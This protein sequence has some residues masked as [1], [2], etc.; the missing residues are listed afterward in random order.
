MN[1]RWDDLPITCGEEGPDYGYFYHKFSHIGCPG[2]GY[3]DNCA[4]PWDCASK[5]RCRDIYERKAFS[6]QER[7]AR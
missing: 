3:E 7:E 6:P 2:C 5:G 4:H 1:K